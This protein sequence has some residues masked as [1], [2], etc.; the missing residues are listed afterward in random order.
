MLE[1]YQQP[2]VRVNDIAA[3]VGLSRSS[4]YWVLEKNGVRP[5]RISR[6][7]RDAQARAVEQWASRSG[8]TSELEAELRA[9][10][11]TVH[12]QNVALQEEVGMLRARLRGFGTMMSRYKHGQMSGQSLAEA[13]WALL[14]EFLPPGEDDEPPRLGNSER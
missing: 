3:E 5:D 11:A 1:L 8:G 6:P 13:A 7:E 4:V 2:D 10:S 14:D 9:S 12:M